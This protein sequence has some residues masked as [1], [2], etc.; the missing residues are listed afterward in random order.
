VDSRVGDGTVAD[1][2]AGPLAGI[3]NCSGDDCSIVGTSRAP[4]EDAAAEGRRVT[5]CFDSFVAGGGEAMPVASMLPAATTVSERAGR[6]RRVGVVVVIMLIMVIMVR[7]LARG[8]P[9][10]R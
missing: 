10:S 9:V 6:E 2:P 8:A 7:F 1:T 3:V 5:L 4:E